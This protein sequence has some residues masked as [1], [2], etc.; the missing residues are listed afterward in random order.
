MVESSGAEQ[1]DANRGLWRRF[2]DRFIPAEERLDALW[3]IGVATLLAI[4]RVL[5]YI[6]LLRFVS[7]HV[8]SPNA[9]ELGFPLRAT[10]ITDVVWGVLAGVFIL[11]VIRYA[12]APKATAL[13][14]VLAGLL[15]TLVALGNRLALNAVSALARSDYRRA[16]WSDL[17]P[18][19]LAAAEAVGVVVGAWTAQLMSGEERPADGGTL[20]PAMGWSAAPRPEATRLAVGYVTVRAVAALAVT[21]VLFGPLAYNGWLF[22][23][24]IVVTPE[25]YWPTL[26]AQSLAVL[27]YFAVG[28]LGVRRY[29]APVTIWLAFLAAGIPGLISA[30]AFLPTQYALLATTGGLTLRSAALSALTLIALPLGTVSPLLGVWLAT[31]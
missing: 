23:K 28:Y 31:R 6:P 29:S 10:A 25:T 26:F 21:L 15:V 4:A 19:M 22:A 20:L 27:V 11:V 24:H 12:K 3:V 14:I 5:A 13:Y 8:V 16:L 18:M 1:P 7:D 30:L 9:E 17:Q 2:L